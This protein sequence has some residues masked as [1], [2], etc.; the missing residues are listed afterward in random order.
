MRGGDPSLQVGADVVVRGGDGGRGGRGAREASFRFPTTESLAA[1]AASSGAMLQR[2][3]SRFTG[4]AF[5]AVVQRVFQEIAVEV[6]PQDAEEALA[7]RA[8]AVAARLQAGPARAR[9]HSGVGPSAVL[10]T[11]R[12][13]AVAGEGDLLRCVE[14][15]LRRPHGLRPYGWRESHTLR[16]PQALRPSG[17]PSAPAHPRAA[18]AAT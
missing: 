2:G 10:P 5:A 18:E 4:A 3:G 9:G 16:R 12:C 8:R 1:L 17:G 14:P 7:V 13:D 15:G 11:A 6:N